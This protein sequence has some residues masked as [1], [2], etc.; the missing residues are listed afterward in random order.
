MATLTEILAWCEQTLQVSQFKDYCPNGLQIEGK[1][2]VQTLVSSVTASQVAIEQAL[3]LKADALIVHHGYFWKGEPSP[4][5][6]IK[7]KRIKQLMQADVS[8]IA[9]HLPL[10][11]HPT[12][13]NN[14]ALADL[15][16]IKITGALDSSERFP[17][18]N[19]GELDTALTPEQFSKRISDVLG[20]KPIHISS[21]KSTIQKVGFCTGGAQ[22]F[23]YKAADFDCDA[24]I[25]G[26][27]SERT[28]HEALEYGVDY[29]AAGHHATER[30]GV[31][32]LAKA[33]AE[34][35]QLTHHYVELSN[36]I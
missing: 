19:I 35:F 16:G 31:Q 14:A 30:Y 2:E 9:Y 5:T 21:G 22:D 4:L 12:L 1:T 24:Y 36:P 17:I 15:L 33:L 27:V 25:S 26:E 23:L 20:Q 34:Q 18:G 32:R 13:G 28:Y 10:D 7:G 6:G 3:D 11:A 29:F 8:L